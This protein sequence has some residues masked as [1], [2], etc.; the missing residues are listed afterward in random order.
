MSVIRS[1]PAN[2]IQDSQGTLTWGNLSRSADLQAEQLALYQKNNTGMW[3]YINEAI[4]CESYQFWLFAFLNILDPSMNDMMTTAAAATYASTV[5]DN[6]A[7]TT[8]QVVDWLTLPDNV[9]T[10]LAAQYKIMAEQLTQGVGQLEILMTML[11]DGDNTIGIQVA[12]QHP[13]SRGTIFIESTDPFTAPLINPDYFG[14]GY[15]I[16]IIS[17]GSEFAR[18]LADSAPLN[19]IL[20]TETLPGAGVTGE[21]LYNYTKQHCG[22]EYHPLGTCAMLPKESGG[23]VDTNLRVYGTSNLRVVDSSVMPLQISAHLMA[24]TYGI[25]EKA[26]DMIKAQYAAKI[27]SSTSSTSEA[28]SRDGGTTATPGRATDTAVAAAANSNALASGMSLGAKIGIGAGVGGG[29]A[30]LLAGL[31]S[32]CLC[33]LAYW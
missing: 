27:V 18:K 22:T 10:G 13:W 9:A 20:I 31:V 24:S 12:L 8:A 11:G 7:S 15:D 17:Y 30:A 28:S 26:S 29:V 32:V 5:T 16:D 25:A 4:G 14:V 3:T 1:Y 21:A 23:V 2:L 19:T 6:L 33:C